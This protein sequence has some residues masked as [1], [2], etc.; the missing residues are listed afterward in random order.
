[1]EL[2]ET[3][4]SHVVCA[5]LGN[6]EKV[7][8]AHYLRVTDEHFDQAI[9]AGRIQR[10]NRVQRHLTVFSR[11]AM[12]A[13]NQ[14]FFAASSIEI[15]ELGIPPRGVER[16]K[17][18]SEKTRGAVTGVAESGAVGNDSGSS[19]TDLAAVVRAWPTLT[20]AK[21]RVIM[22]VVQGQ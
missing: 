10:T 14:Q 11:P 9:K 6:S 8:R 2:E 22:G 19:D 4:P 7:A 5:W 18:P 1:M 16:T 13:R 17:K 12:K 3:F 15:E 20:P 21:R